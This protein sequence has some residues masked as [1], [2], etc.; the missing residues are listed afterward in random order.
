MKINEMMAKRVEP[1]EFSKI[2]QYMTYV[3]STYGRGSRE[4]KIAKKITNS[5]FEHNDPDTAMK[6][7]AEKLSKLFPESPH[8]T[9]IKKLSKKQKE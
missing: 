8:L 5:F 3:E 1:E 6:I 4:Y 2:K 7:I 9:S